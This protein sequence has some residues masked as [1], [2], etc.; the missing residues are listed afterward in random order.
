MTRDGYDVRTIYDN[1]GAVAGYVWHKRGH[2][3]G[4]N[5]RRLLRVLRAREAPWHLLRYR[6]CGRGRGGQRQVGCAA[7]TSH[8][9]T[10]R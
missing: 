2:R 6:D 4:C 3:M 10:P 8:K 5:P 9:Q 7:M 1:R